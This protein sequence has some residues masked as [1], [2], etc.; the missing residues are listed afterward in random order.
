MIPQVFSQAITFITECFVI[1]T[2]S[3]SYNKYP[4]KGI[5]EENYT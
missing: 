5:Y 3:N 2:I 4:L 1:G